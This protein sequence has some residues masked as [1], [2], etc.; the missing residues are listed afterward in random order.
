MFK[1]EL[2]LITPSFNN[3]ELLKRLYLS[4]KSQTYINLCWIIINDGSTDN[5][6]KIVKTFSDILI[7][8]KK[9]NNQGPN[10]CRNKA[11]RLIPSSCKYVIPIDSD[12]KF[13]NSNTLAS[14]V[15]DIKKTHKKIGMIGYA[16]IDGSTGKKVSFLK[17]PEITINYLDNLKG[18][19]YSGEFLIIQK[20]HVIKHSKWPNNIWGYEAI[21]HWEINKHYDF[22]Y[23]ESPGRIYFRDR[24]ENLTSPESTIARAQ[25]MIDGI[26]YLILKHGN[27]LRKYAMERYVYFLF[28]KALYLLL[29][30]QKTKTIKHMVSFMRMKKNIKMTMLGLTILFSLPMPISLITK[31]YLSIKRINYNYIENK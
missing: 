26:D 22:I 27:M 30:N 1:P 15:N 23:K 16:S 20:K 3:G 10:N 18:E 12:D 5:T 17:A 4:I 28:T 24:K 7:I 9:Q 11:E 29:T 8:Y 13:Y 31:I 25:K 14:M 2:A 6:D 21:R 19:M